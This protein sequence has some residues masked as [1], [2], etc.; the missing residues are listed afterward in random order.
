[1]DNSAEYLSTEIRQLQRDLQEL[2]KSLT[3]MITDLATLRVVLDELKRRT[4]TSEENITHVHSQNKGRCD[5]LEEDVEKT[6]RK[7]VELVGKV[8]NLIEARSA[9]TACCAEMKAER[10]GTEKELYLRTDNIQNDLTR[11]ECAV[12]KHEKTFKTAIGWSIGVAGL[13]G[14]AI[15]FLWKLLQ[16]GAV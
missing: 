9:Q 4:D 3:P 12:D 16:Q 5:A 14:S 11:V 2:T 10:R 6:I 7:Q 13:V 8:S 15:S 1:M